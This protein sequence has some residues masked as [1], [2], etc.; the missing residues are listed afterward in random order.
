MGKLGEKIRDGF[1]HHPGGVVY[2]VGDLGMGKTTLSRAIIRAF[3]WKLAVKSPTYNLV[4][5]YSFDALE[6]HHFDLYRISDP[7]ELE[8][9][10][11]DSYFD[12]TSINLIEWPERGAPVLPRADLTIHLFEHDQGRKLML[13]PHSHIGLSW[14]QDW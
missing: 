3:G 1:K 14:C 12:D 2:L 5:S 9:L 13:Q 7:E 11:L 6:I 8:Y 10:G 4:E